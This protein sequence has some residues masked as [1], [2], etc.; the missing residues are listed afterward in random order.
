MLRKGISKVKPKNYYHILEDSLKRYFPRKSSEEE[1]KEVIFSA[2][3]DAIDT[4]SKDFSSLITKMFIC[5]KAQ[6]SRSTFIGYMLTTQSTEDLENTVK[7]WPEDVQEE[8]RK[9]IRFLTRSIYHQNFLDC[10]DLNLDQ[11]IDIGVS[12]DEE[13]IDTKLSR[14]SASK[15]FRPFFHDHL[16]SSINEVSQKMEELLSPLIE[17]EKV[18]VEEF[19]SEVSEYLNGL[20]ALDKM[21]ADDSIQDALQFTVHILQEIESM[22][23]VE[24]IELLKTF[25]D[26]DFDEETGFSYEDYLKEKAVI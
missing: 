13:L 4:I 8:A 6:T 2:A 17:N 22:S 24:V 16:V 19:V 1:M 14:K 11:D 23:D 25:T 15:I 21:C 7:S 10:L 3:E 18:M 20:I 26:P 9:N 12:L 5:F